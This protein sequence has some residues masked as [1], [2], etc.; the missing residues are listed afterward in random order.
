MIQF[1]V[2]WRRH[3]KPACLLMQEHKPFLL[4]HADLGEVVTPA[5]SHAQSQH[6]EATLIM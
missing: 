3:M 2:H 6:S 1:D 5:L 4:Y